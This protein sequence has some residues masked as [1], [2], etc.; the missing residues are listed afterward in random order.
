MGPFQSKK[1]EL[2][3][4]RCKCGALIEAKNGPKETWYHM[5]RSLDGFDKI[6]I[7][8]GCHAA[9]PTN[10][11][12][13]TEPAIE[14]TEY[15]IEGLTGVISDA[16]ICLTSCC[17]LNHSGEGVK[18]AVRILIHR[19]RKSGRKEPSWFRSFHEKN[20]WREEIL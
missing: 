11:F 14:E 13:S 6:P 7:Q 18:G 4:S 20:C 19:L 8:D 9:E 16:V 5:D 10:D 3:R 15:A 1:P 17:D 12:L 2:L